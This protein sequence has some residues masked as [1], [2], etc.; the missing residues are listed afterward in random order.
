MKFV[1]KIL[2]LLFAI[3]LTILLCSENLFAYN[4]VH[5]NKRR[6]YRKWHDTNIRKGTKRVG[7][8]I[9]RTRQRCWDMN[10]DGWLSPAEE[11]SMKRSTRRCPNL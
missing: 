2:I 3:T 1:P 6:Y 8:T 7:K 9:K 5:P 10:K 11:F 4:S